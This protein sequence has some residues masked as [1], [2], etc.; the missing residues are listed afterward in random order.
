MLEDFDIRQYVQFA[1]R[2][3]WL[4]LLAGLVAGGVGYWLELRKPIRYQAR[5]TLM[6]YQGTSSDSNS[7]VYADVVANERVAPTYAQLLTRYPVLESVIN[8]N[9]LPLSP[10]Q[11][12]GMISAKPVANTN[13]IELL[14]I[15]TDSVRASVIANT[16]PTVFSAYNSKLQSERYAQKKSDSQIELDTLNRRIL[17]TQIALN[18]LGEPSTVEEEADQARL[19]TQLNQYRQSYASALNTYEQ[20]RIAENRSTT[21]NLVAYEMATSP[22]P[23]LARD[24]TRAGASAFA[25]AAL[26]AGVFAYLWDYFDDTFKLPEQIS[27]LTGLPILSVIQQ[28]KADNM[29]RG[30]VAQVE[31]RSPVSE[32][33]RML[34]TNLQ[35]SGVDRQKRVIVVTSPQMGDGKST[36]AANLA[37]VMAQSGKKVLLIDGDL[38]RPSL[39]TKFD[40]P[41]R[42]GLTDLL[43]NHDFDTT[44]LLATSTNNLFFLPSG[45]IPP[46][47]AELLGSDSM[48]RLIEKFSETFDC[49]LIDAPPVTAVSDPII[50]GRLSDGFILVVALK[51]S[52]SKLTQQTCEQL[53]RA[54]IPMLGLAVNFLRLQDRGYYYYYYQYDQ[55]YAKQ[56]FLQRLLRTKHK[57][58]TDPTVEIEA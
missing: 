23:A 49:V 14:V 54:N 46:N 48:R 6:I 29:S 17:E 16:L 53:K 4:L 22:A 39:H 44:A 20:L 45:N 30:L 19:Q 18:V 7:N 12:A 21:N 25:V 41:N 57:R 27:T 33:Y 50:L 26:L 8:N 37:I 52:K 5:A 58:K 56:N 38:R 10:A 43:V 34:R 32:A 36:T 40:L 2:W 24:M 47:P 11:L 31:P 35:F 9:K 51:Q 3:W 28:Q 15:D 13:L 1:R 42:Y 55:D